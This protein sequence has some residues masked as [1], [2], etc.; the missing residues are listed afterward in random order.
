M[1][2]RK[3]PYIAIKERMGVP[4]ILISRQGDGKVV[5]V[6]SPSLDQQLEH[7]RETLEMDR[8]NMIRD[9][10][11][12][13]DPN[14]SQED[15]EEARARLVNAFRQAKIASAAI[16]IVKDE[17]NHRVYQPSVEMRAR[18]KIKKITGQMGGTP[19][20]ARRFANMFPRHTKG[21]QRKEIQETRRIKKEL[22]N[23]QSTKTPIYK[24]VFTRRC[25]QSASS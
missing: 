14:K 1:K 4:L 11:I 21:V 22:E 6:T 25:L 5:I 9:L 13:E 19:D 12:R 3:Y 15:K 7:G 24:R 8:P 18:W 20:Q 23:T 17:N 2:E 16:G 10:L